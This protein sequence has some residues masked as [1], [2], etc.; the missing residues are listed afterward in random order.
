[1]DDTILEGIVRTVS[2]LKRLGLSCVIVLDCGD[3][4]VP[5]HEVPR[6]EVIFQA[7]RLVTLLQ[8]E[9]SE[10]ARRL[11]DIFVV[12]EVSKE[13]NSTVPVRGSI[14][15]HIKDLLLHPLLNGVTPVIPPVAHTASSQKIQDVD[16]DDVVLALTREFAGLNAPIT[17]TLDSEG[18]LEQPRPI[19]RKTKSDFIL[20]RIILLDPL[21]GIPSTNRQKKSH[22]FV[23]LEQEFDDIRSELLHPE[24][25]HKAQKSQGANRDI[26]GDERFSVFGASNP[27]SKFSES[28]TNTLQGESHEEL[29]V[30]GGTPEEFRQHLKNLTLLKKT[31]A[32][33]PAT[34]SALLTTPREAATLPVEA[35]EDPTPGVGTRR[36]KNPLVFNLL[37]DKSLISS[38]L[39]I[40]RLGTGLSKHQSAASTQ[41]SL[42]TLLKRGMPLTIIPDPREKSWEPP[43]P[44]DKPMSLEDPRI[45]FPRL[46][47]LI[48]DSFGR[49]LDVDDYLNR[50]RNRI[51]GVIVAGEYEGGAILTWELP[52][53][54]PD[55]GSEGSRRRMVPYLDKFAVLKRSQG[56]GGVADI[57][58]SAMVRSCLPKGVCWRS[59]NDNPV[60][61]WYFERSVGTWKLPES[62]WTMFWTTDDLT[63][64]AQR[65]LDYES[66]CRSIQP[67]WADNKH[68]VD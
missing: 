51:A 53:D 34:S 3:S 23:N 14:E 28:Q 36:V 20:D 18:T 1:M 65:W 15:V 60:N 43:S 49:P 4:G 16:P 41:S 59:R 64:D 11:Q 33:L 61:K 46:L 37:T 25:T 67:S 56:A 63:G 42:A 52:P 31:L 2:Q 50:I 24:R 12:D 38:S 6:A 17:S 32:L 68:I 62:K 7:D 26:E 22:V 30:H 66:V 55:E 58:F 54:V 45:D 21:G 57:V 5:T 27:M 13:I 8:N 40:A 29:E 48:E 39:P 47:H 9:T 19:D 35:Q 44:G 10:G